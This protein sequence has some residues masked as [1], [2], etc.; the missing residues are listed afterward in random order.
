MIEVHDLSKRYA[1]KLA[2]AGVS[3]T[4]RPGQI[5]GLLGPNGAGKSTTI[6]MLVGILAPTSG[7]IEICGHDLAL[8]P[9]AAKRR[10]GYVPDS[11]ALYQTLTPHEYLALVA[12]LHEMPRAEA[13][14][15]IEQLLSAFQ[16]TDAATKQ[17]VALSKGM[18]QKTLI[19]SALLP[20]PDVLLLDEPLSG[21][22]VNAALTF[23]RLLEGLASRGK[24]IVFCSHILDLV[25]RLCSRV[26]LLNE[27]RIVAD[28][29]TAELIARSTQPTL[30]GVFQSLTRRDDA[31]KHVSA[32]LDAV[33][34]PPAGSHAPESV[35][36]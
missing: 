9:L 12:E 6:K 31:D 2:V 32:F 20:D 8:D 33:G 16:L 3:F 21:L 17:I 4:I 29:A 26:I 34:T 18:R 13:A 15:R 36:K 30:E 35:R 25:E 24:T 22:D 1:D 14:E 27:G 7:R 5:T 10:M 19:A 28:E 23:R 11:G